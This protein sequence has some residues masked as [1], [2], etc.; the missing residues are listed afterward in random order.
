MILYQYECYECEG[1]TDAM[2]DIDDRDNAPECQHCGG[3]TRKIISAYKVHGD[4]NPYYDDNLETYITS[5]QHRQVVMKQKGV[6]ENYGQGW[7]TSAIKKRN[8][9]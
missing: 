5:K 7:Y 8:T 2:R 1:L 9:A 3:K 4:L 6:S